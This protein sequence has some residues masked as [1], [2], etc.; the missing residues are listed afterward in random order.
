MLGSFSCRR[1]GTFLPKL[2]LFLPDSKTFVILYFNKGVV[3][4]L[5]LFLGTHQYLPFLIKPKWSVGFGKGFF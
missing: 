5:R 4:F 1:E 3:L 2:Y